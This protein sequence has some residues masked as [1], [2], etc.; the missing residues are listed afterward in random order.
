MPRAFLAFLALSLTVAPLPAPPRAVHTFESLV[1]ADAILVGRV[2]AIRVGDE[3]PSPRQPSRHPV[4][5]HV[6]EVEIRRYRTQQEQLQEQLADGRI[7]EIAYRSEILDPKAA[8]VNPPYYPRIAEGE[9]RIF[10]VRR[11]ESGALTL[12]LES[13]EDSVPPAHGLLLSD[14]PAVTALEFLEREIAAALA[15]GDAAVA[16]EMARH[17]GLAVWSPSRPH[18]VR[19]QLTGFLARMLGDDLARTREAAAAML[20]SQGIPRPSV[21][22]L[23]AGRGVEGRRLSPFH[24]LQRWTILQLPE[25]DRERLLIETLVEN[26]PIYSWGATVT[27]REFA[28]HPALDAPLAAAIA[29]R[30]RGVLYLLEALI[31]EGRVDLA[32]AALDIVREHI[33]DPVGLAAEWPVAARLLWDHGSAGDFESFFALIPQTQQNDPELYRRL[34]SAAA[35][36]QPAPPEPMLRF[37]A[38]FLADNRLFTGDA[39]YSD[40]ALSRLSVLS[41]DRFGLEENKWP[42]EIRIADRDAAI[43]RAARW[44]AQQLEQAP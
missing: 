26:L 43:Q 6:A 16:L 39:R 5:E 25:Q 40:L 23:L 2:V 21:A 27:L 42:G 18:E 30:R 9:V 8:Q 12:W 36:H 1:P 22:D 28:R 11:L 24:Q 41:G 10:A 37:L 35:H 13:G 17:A 44:L 29:Q 3:V 38:I 7:V 34:W 19:P 14:V 31:R 32:P 4:R 15:S 33:G 20:A